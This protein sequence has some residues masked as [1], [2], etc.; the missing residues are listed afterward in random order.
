MTYLSCRF[1]NHTFNLTALLLGL[2]VFHPAPTLAT[3]T[4][5][6]GNVQAGQAIRAECPIGSFL[7]GFA[8]Q[9]GAWIDRIAPVCEPL[10]ADKQRLGKFTVGPMI[11]T[12]MGG[13]P[14]HVRCPANTIIRV[15]VHSVTVGDQGQVKFVESIHPECFT[16][17]GAP[18]LGQPVS[19]F[20]T[21]PDRPIIDL[22]SKSLDDRLE[23][24]PGEFAR[25]F[26]VR[27]SEFINAF[28]LICGPLVPRLPGTGLPADASK[29]TSAFPT[30]P[31]I[32]SPLPNGLI[33]KGKGIFKITPSKYLTGT[34]AQIQLKWLNPPANRQGKGLDFYNYEVPMALIAGP[35][36]IDAP[37]I[38]LA[39]GTWELRVRINQP[40]VGD[41]SD[42]VRFTYYLQH[43][44]LGTTAQDVQTQDFQLGVGGRQK[45][46]SGNSGTRFFRP[47]MTPQQ[48]MGDTTLIRPR[49]VDEK[50]GKANET[51]ETS[52]GAGSKP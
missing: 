37:A 30:A 16:T 50:E 44:A 38:Y 12:S 31:R 8:G 14:D 1:L 45:T 10:L 42:W 3:D 9:T 17:A 27:A 4:P 22:T 5:M 52:S 35:N 28:G 41:W 40:K 13:K 34:G 11:G 49:G 26:N 23:C 51:T 18:V 21:P 2:F 39:P 25:G 24:P 43:P 6:K 19:Y 36:G 29:A 46:M 33:V 32:D 7:V 20:G 47:Q 48:G 15:T